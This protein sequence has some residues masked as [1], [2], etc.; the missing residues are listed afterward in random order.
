MLKKTETNLDSFEVIGLSVRTRNSDEFNPQTA[1][2]GA[3]IQRYL[4]LHKK[5]ANRLNQETTL[6]VYTDYEHEH[7]GAYTFLIGSVVE[8]GTQPPEGFTA[9]TIP[10]QSYAK[11][12]TEVG[13]MPKMEIDA[14][15]KI[16]S[17]TPKELDGERAYRT[18][19]VVYDDRLEDPKTSAIDILIGLK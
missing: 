15:L 11:F 12:T 14:W 4:G 7:H 2:I 3:I 18:D 13:A 17:M 5:I 10:A 9:R 19:L 1:K 8:P 6:A 16:W